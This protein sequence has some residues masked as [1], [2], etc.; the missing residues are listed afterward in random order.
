MRRTLLF[1][2]I[3]L[4]LMLG[5]C[6]QTREKDLQARLDK[7]TAERL[8]LQDAL[9]D[10]E[11]FVDQILKSVNEIYEDMEAARAKQ[12]KMLPAQG[13]RGAMEIPW[14]SSKETRQGFLTTL[15]E[16]GSTLKGNRKKIT[17]L[18]AR[19]RSYRGEVKNLTAL[20]EK[21]KADI[22]QREEA[23][24]QL[25]GQVQGLEQTVAEKV[26]IVSEKE[27]VI[28]QQKQQMNKVF[29]VAGTRKELEEKGIITEEGGFLWGLLGS[30]TILSPEANLDDFTPLDRSAEQ[31]IH[32][33]G[34]I[35][36]ILPPRKPDYYAMSVDK[37]KGSDLKILRP[38]KFWQGNTL[39]V[40]LD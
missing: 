1:A 39:V 13:E 3:I 31:T 29:Y 36:D 26:R 34:K 21:L 37:E 25:R 6:D 28:D 15:D 19:V 38:D 22:Q 4:A 18:E 12:Q 14:V 9:K 33:P 16:I 8:A 10:R 5:G 7:N 30:T 17:D 2:G 20:L 27:T 24:A 35:D 32:L 40:V 11:Q 23:I